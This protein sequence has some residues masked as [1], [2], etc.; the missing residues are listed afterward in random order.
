MYSTKD[1]ESHKK[2]PPRN[3]KE[4]PKTKAKGSLKIINNKRKKDKVKTRTRKKPRKKPANKKGKEESTKA[5]PKQGCSKERSKASLGKIPA[6]GL[7]IC[8]FPYCDQV[9]IRR[10]PHT[11]PTLKVNP[12]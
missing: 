9:L 4:K 7:I 11:V 12:V 6:A 5:Q 8:P 1:A 2:R 10:G 3:L